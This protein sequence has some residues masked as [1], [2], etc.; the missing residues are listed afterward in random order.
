MASNETQRRIAKLL[1]EV[2]QAFAQQD[3]MTAQERCQEVLAL[4]PDNPEAITF[5][6]KVDR[7]LM[8]Q[9]T[10]SVSPEE[11][12]E[13]RTKGGKGNGLST[14][15]MWIVVIVMVRQDRQG[16]FSWFC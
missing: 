1:D 16:A 14:V 10:T 2:E 12:R 11:S 3:W 9:L 6:A 15:I 5:L 8:V 13:S 7:L 4:D